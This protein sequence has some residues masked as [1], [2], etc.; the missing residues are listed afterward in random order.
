MRASRPRFRN[1]QDR[2]AFVVHATMLVSGYRPVAM[3]RAAEREVQPPSQQGDEVEE[4]VGEEGW[5]ELP[6][7]YAFRYVIDGS[8]DGGGNKTSTGKRR[9]VVKCLA[10]GD[11]L[12]VDAIDRA[13]DSGEPVHLEVK[14]SDSAVESGSSNYGD[15]YKDL[16]SL[17]KKV[18]TS[19]VSALSGGGGTRGPAGGNRGRT[20]GVQMQA[21]RRQ[22]VGEAPGRHPAP[23][24]IVPPVAGDPLRGDDPLRDPLREPLRVGGVYRPG[25]GEDLYPTGGAGI[26]PGGPGGFA[27]GGILGP[28]GFPGSGGGMLLG[29]NDPRWGSYVEGGRGGGGGFG[30]FPP[31]GRGGVPPGLPPGAR[32]DPFGPPGVPGFEPNRFMGGGGGGRPSSVRPPHPDLEHFQPPF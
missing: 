22:D 15:H 25:Y 24:S 27:G 20:R 3:G 13:A 5:N 17:V 11:L 18:E 2:V 9:V 14:V 1:L 31:G 10:M 32:F 4:E 29:P 19:I 30:A 26:L 6:D 8:G 7:S 21:E 28:G 23:G 12:L 16:P